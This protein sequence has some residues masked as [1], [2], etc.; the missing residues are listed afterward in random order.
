MPGECT[1][2]GQECCSDPDVRDE[3]VRQLRY[4]S[5]PGVLILNEVPGP[6]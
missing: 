3:V 1:M 6:A 2:P 5:P 4:S